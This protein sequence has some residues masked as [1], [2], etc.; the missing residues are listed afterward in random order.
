MAAQPRFTEMFTLG[1]LRGANRVYQATTAWLV[2]L[3]WP[4]FLLA[5]FFGPE[6]LTVFGH[7]YRAG[8]TVLVIL[9]LAMLLATAC[10][11]V[12]MVLVT[13]GR[14]SWSLVNGL[15]AVVINVGL[16]VLLIP[17]Y[18]ITGAA[19]GWAAAIAV[20]NLMP[21]AQLMVTVRLHPLGRGTLIAIALSCLSFGLLPLAIRVLV[22][23]GVVPSVAAIACGCIVMAAGMW[24]FRADLYLAAW[25]GAARLTAVFGGSTSTTDRRRRANGIG[26]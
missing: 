23:H 21:L 26:A 4:M 9:S 1:D 7:S 25:P 24:R 12:D 18:G 14:S 22:G 6:I 16:D 2:L 17:R 8:D 20:T 13:T 3:T 15:L 10:G 5:V 11:Q 19:I